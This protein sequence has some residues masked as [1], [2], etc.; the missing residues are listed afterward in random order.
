MDWTHGVAFV[1]GFVFFV[2]LAFGRKPKG[3]VHTRRDF[4]AS[5]AL[6]ARIVCEP[7]ASRYEIAQ[8]AVRDADALMK[9]LD[10]K[11]KP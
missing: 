11:G 6:R 7:G 9:A 8:E 2:A 4:M 5:S 1:L 10:E 3:E